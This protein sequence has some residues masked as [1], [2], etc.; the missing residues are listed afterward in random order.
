MLIYSAQTD[1]YSVRKPRKPFSTVLRGTIT[2][3]P[4][5]RQRRR[6]SMPTRRISQRF[7]PQGCG[8]F[9]L[10]ICPTEKSI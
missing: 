9:I 6:K 1:G 10:I 8:F 5:R 3:R 2:W 4:Q 7:S